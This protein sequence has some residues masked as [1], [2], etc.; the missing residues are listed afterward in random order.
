[1]TVLSAHLWR[2]GLTDSGRMFAVVAVKG[3]YRIPTGELDVDAPY[4]LSNTDQ[5]T[6]LGTL[7]KDMVPWKKSVDVYVLGK[8]RSERPV[9]SL[10]CSVSVGPLQRSFRVVG[11][12]VW[13]RT[14]EG[15]V[16]SRPQPFTEMPVTWERAF[17]GVAGEQRPPSVQSRRQGVRAR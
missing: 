15:L 8:A 3:T 11:D 4:A 14:P 16:P 5:P 1:M 9:E 2:S 10:A 12:R 17:G 13:Q 7:P 6:E